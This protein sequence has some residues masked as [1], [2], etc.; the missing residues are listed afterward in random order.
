MNMQSERN[1]V[2]FAFGEN[3][4]RS[5]LD[6]KGDPWF[7]AKDVALALNYQWNGQS[8]IAHVPEEWRGVR[9]VLTPS[10]TQE[11][12]MLSEQGLYF[13]LG[14][15]DKPKALSFQKWLAGEVLPTLRRTGTYTMPNANKLRG[16]RTGMPD[17]PEVYSLRQ[18]IR[19]RVWESAL[20][21]ASLEEEGWDFAV[22]CFVH[23]CR[24]LAAGPLPRPVHDEETRRIVRFAEEKCRADEHGRVN[25]TRL[26]DAFT[27]WWCGK[28]NEPVPS[29]HIFG[30]VMPTRFARRKRGGKSVYFG[31]CLNHA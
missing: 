1:L 28:F 2:P 14:R 12:L 18:G 24:M 9:S 17:V 5:M 29:Q 11:M 3:L 6:E 15:S 23:I 22:Q 4:V 25:A 19:L 31:L 16:E 7:V 20:R 13:F 26:Y 21:C 30:R 10:G 27:A 8:C